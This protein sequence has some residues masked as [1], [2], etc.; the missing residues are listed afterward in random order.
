M[1]RRDI[2]RCG[3]GDRAHRD[4]ERARL[5]ACQDAVL[6]GQYCIKG[7]IVG[8]HAKDDV[9]GGSGVPG[10][11]CKRGACID[12]GTGF[13]RGPVPHDDIMPCAYKIGR[14]GSAHLSKSKKTDF[15][16]PPLTEDR[17]SA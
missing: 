3:D 16:R 10:T 1:A 15:H 9:A 6:S 11:C 4:M 8:K 7:C 12:Q 13:L 2:A 17:S 5:E 14:D